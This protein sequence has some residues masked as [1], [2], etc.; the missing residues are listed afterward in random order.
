MKVTPAILLLLA[1]GACAPEV[2]A[3]PTWVDDVRPILAANCI[4]CHSPPYIGGAP[5]YFR[6]DKFD[7]D[8]V[9]DL[10][11]D[12]P[13][14]GAE[15]VGSG[16]A[17]KDVLVT[18]STM[19]PRF[20]LT[21][22]QVDVL[23][24]WHDAS[25]PKGDPRDNNTAPTM[26]VVGDLNVISAG[27]IGFQYEIDDADGDIVTGEVLADPGGGDTPSAESNELFAGRGTVKFSLAA[28]TYQLSAELDDGSDEVTVDLGQV[29]VP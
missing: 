18:R 3:E 29:V 21:D 26:T 23:M 2:P 17:F 12:E 10:E 27:R 15:Y 6:L 1:A 28:G 4:R 11:F 25:T 22:R 8:L 14:R 5:Q 19:P 20:P 13:V 7:D 16:D 24:A 9:I